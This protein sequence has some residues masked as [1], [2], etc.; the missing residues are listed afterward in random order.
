MLLTRY[1][2][3]S[4]RALTRLDRVLVLLVASLLSLQLLSVG[5][6]KDDHVGY[7]DNCS[8]CFFAH[9][10]PHGLP[11]VEPALVPARIAQWYR[12]DRPAIR[13][14]CVSPSF[15]IPNAQAPPR[16]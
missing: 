3:G 8:S 9:Q 4:I 7:Q 11:D 15:L 16:A 2:S 13:Q 5:H 10:V 6:H 12:I 14:T 1:V